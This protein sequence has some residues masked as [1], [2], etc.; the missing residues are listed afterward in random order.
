MLP[1]DNETGD[2]QDI[3]SSDVSDIDENTTVSMSRCI[4]KILDDDLQAWET[5]Q[6]NA[7]FPKFFK[8]ERTM[9]LLLSQPM[10]AAVK[11]KCGE[12]HTTEDLKRILGMKTKHLASS[13]VGQMIPSMFECITESLAKTENMERPRQP[14][15]PPAP[16]PPK[17]VSH[18]PFFE[19]IEQMQYRLDVEEY[20]QY[21]ENDREQR[22]VKRRKNTREPKKQNRQRA[23]GGARKTKGVR[24]KPLSAIILN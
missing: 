8:P 20:E 12:V 24:R 6:V 4:L 3:D 11:R 2:A 5:R 18:L 7:I 10:I 9:G 1:I 21:K 14:P 13:A 16:E 19:T 23:I 22:K 15:P 17:G